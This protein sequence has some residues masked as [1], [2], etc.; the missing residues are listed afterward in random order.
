MAVSARGLNARA[1]P[2]TWRITAVPPSCCSRHT[3]AVGLRNAR[4]SVV[5]YGDMMMGGGLDRATTG[6]PK[7]HQSATKG[8]PKGQKNQSPG[9]PFTEDVLGLCGPLVVVVVVD[10]AVWPPGS[11]LARFLAGPGPP[12]SIRDCFW[13][14]AS[15]V[16][17]THM[18]G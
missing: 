5:G 13:G 15:P 4:P 6:P 11:V 12:L 10:S 9:P 7:G 3:A 1:P 8:P 14:G 17:K 16:P 2:L 18:G